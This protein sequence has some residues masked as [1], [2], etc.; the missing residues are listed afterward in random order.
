[1]SVISARIRMRRGPSA[2]WAA[3][4]PILLD[5]E[6]AFETDTG[7]FRIGDGVTRFLDLP[8]ASVSDTFVSST[9]S[10]AIAA[11]KSSAASII[12]SWTFNVGVKLLSWLDIGPSSECRIAYSK[13]Y[14]VLDIVGK[15]G[16]P[17][18]NTTALRVRSRYFRIMN[19]DGNKFAATF[20]SDGVSALR[21]NG[22]QKLAT[23]P[24]GVDISGAIAADSAAGAMLD[25]TDGLTS[26][27]P[28]RLPTVRAARAYLD[29]RTLTKAIAWA[30][31]SNSDSDLTVLE[32]RG[33]SD[34]TPPARTG[35]G[36]YAF[37]FDAPQADT[38]Y[39]VDLCPVGTANVAY[40][41]Q[42]KSA[43]GFT[44]QTRSASQAGLLNVAFTIEVRRLS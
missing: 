16:E 3:A 13:D 19:T 7:L 1:M 2:S 20:D 11:M 26:N 31:V 41:L 34:D 21:F 30:V 38:N 39:H 35:T 25:N 4:N 37:V 6:P 18:E 23:G 10:A 36:T 40:G 22:S 5:G 17:G 27:S 28:S 29:E 43:T 15:L 33:F 42:Y 12:G 8:A 9:V 14:D 24:S 32:S 44:I